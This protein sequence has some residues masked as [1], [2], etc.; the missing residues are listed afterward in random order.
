[1]TTNGL[2]SLPAPAAPTADGIDLVEIGRTVRRGWRHVIGF[3]LLGTLGAA[4]VIAWAPRRFDGSA[5]VVLKSAADLGSALLGSV[6]AGAATGAGGA[7]GAMPSMGGLGALVGAAGSPMETEIQILTSRAVAREVI[8]SLGLDV[9]VREPAGVPARALVREARLAP[10]FKRR[11]LEFVREGDGRTWRV[12]SKDWAGRAAAGAPLETP[13]GTL[14][15]RESGALPARFVLDLLDREDAGTFFTRRLTIQKAG[16]EVARVTWRGDDSLTAARVPNVLL[17]VYLARRKTVDRGINTHRA[18]FLQAQSDSVS[19]E[20]ATAERALREYQERSGVIEPVVVG[21]IQLEQAAELRAVLSQVDVEKGAIDHMLAQ[22]GTGKLTAR[23]LIAY[24]EFLKSQGVNELLSQMGELETERE[25][26]LERRT[27]ADPEV[28]ALGQGVKNLE[29][30]LAPLAQAYA[31]SLTTRR[32]DL[33]AQ[34]DTMR[35]ALGVLPGAAESS[36]R[37]QRDVIRLGTIY[38]AL[39][40]QLVAA[41]LAAIGE[42]G[43]V[44]QLDAAEPSKKAA[45]PQP[46]LTMGLGVTGGFACGLV[47]ALLVGLL[48][49]WGADPREMERSMGVPVLRFDPAEPLVLGAPTARTLLLVPLEAGADTG[50]V[51]RRLARTATAR[52][53]EVAVLAVGARRS[54]TGESAESA[55]Q[56]VRQLEAA[57]DGGLVLVQTAGLADDETAALLDGERPVLLVAPA[58]PVDRARAAQA[59]ETLRRLDVPIA[60]VVMRDAERVGLRAALGARRAPL[61]V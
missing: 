36:N 35:A 46:I 39:Q 25:K 37:L 48:G 2:R 29:G 6:G 59:V 17:G 40:A 41:R 54:A 19:R 28:I 52:G 3:T 22:F 50:E 38:A 42:G 60:G 15:L 18:E 56:A 13:A 58:G 26:L 51:A 7:A 53:T 45:F 9:R 5:T 21:K 14:V 31:A 27:E 57:T 32:R 10:A 44:R 12:S 43:D 16:G 55:L 20:L 8:D 49:R 24:P 11:R 1:M 4:A 23:Q 34:L 61:P 33:A 47:A 30:Q